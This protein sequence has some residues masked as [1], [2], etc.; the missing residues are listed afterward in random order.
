[1]RGGVSVIS[2]AALAAAAATAAA[3]GA[4]AGGRPRRPRPRRRT[5]RRRGA[6]AARRGGGGGGGLQAGPPPRPP[7][8]QYPQHQHHQHQYLFR[9]LRVCS[10]PSSFSPP[11][12]F[13]VSLLSSSVSLLLPLLLLSLLSL[14]AAP[15]I[16]TPPYSAPAEVAA[17]L[18]TAPTGGCGRTWR[19][20][21][22]EYSGC[23]SRRVIKKYSARAHAAPPRLR[24]PP[25][26]SPLSRS[27]LDLS[28]PPLTAAAMPDL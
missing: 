13:L 10:L 7:S 21:T 9:T 20:G 24:T 12:L 17:W 8:P 6:A 5:L 1:M 11:P 28:L 26:H 4:A 14:S 23:S 25:P 2:C 18:T 22:S 19:S 27:L 3:A 16:S 15:L